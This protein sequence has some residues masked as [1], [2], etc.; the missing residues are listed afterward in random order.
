[1]TAPTLLPDVQTL[2]W[3]FVGSDMP[4]MLRE[5]ADRLES[6]EVCFLGAWNLGAD[7]DPDGRDL[8]QVLVESL[9]DSAPSGGESA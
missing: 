5:V 6:G 9:E 1:M 7:G 3:Q 4:T 8:L 2:L